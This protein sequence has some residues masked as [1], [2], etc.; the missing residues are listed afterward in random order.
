MEEYTLSFKNDNERIIVVLMLILSVF[1][2]FIPSIIVV[3]LCPNLLGENSL[4]FAKALFNFEVTLLI[5]AAILGF[6]SLGVFAGLIY[7][8]NI[9]ILLMGLVSI[10]QNSPIKLIKGIKL[11]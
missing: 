11:L 8:A 6:V 10:S 1:M 5:L 9:I 3:L 7:L 4:N 2:W